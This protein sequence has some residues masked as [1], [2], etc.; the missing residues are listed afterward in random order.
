MEAREI[1][2]VVFRIG[3]QEY[4]AEISKVQEIVR[5][6]PIIPAPNVPPYVVG[7]VN[8][9]GKVIP[10]YDLRERF[11]LEKVAISK[12]SRILILN[13]S[14][15]LVGVKVD[16]ASEVIAIPEDK[17]ELPPEEI[18]GVDEGIAGIAKVDDRLIILLDLERILQSPVREGVR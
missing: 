15:R 9:R 2:V 1:Q 11:G 13:F 7:V 3:D 12:Q 18:A 16:A 14:K 8:L 6:L 4:G 17:I 5:M 10:V